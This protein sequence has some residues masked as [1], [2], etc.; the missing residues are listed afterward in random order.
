MKKKIKS[1]FDKYDEDNRKKN[2]R[3]LYILIS[4][5]VVPFILTITG[6][7][8]K[9]FDFLESGFFYG[10]IGLYFTIVFIANLFIE[11][12]MGIL[13]LNGLFFGKKEPFISPSADIYIPIIYHICLYLVFLS[14]SWY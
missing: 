2:K 10:V 4:L 7:T 12:F 3:D 11:F 1:I 8:F 13:F 6:I 14:F 5:T 9:I